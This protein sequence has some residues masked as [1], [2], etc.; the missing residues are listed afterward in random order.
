MMSEYLDILLAFA[1]AVLL[2]FLM[3][4]MYKF[5]R[6]MDDVRENGQFAPLVFT[7]ETPRREFRR[8][9][10]RLS[11]YASIAGIIVALIVY[12]VLRLNGTIGSL[13]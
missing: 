11:K 13:F 7:R 12:S 3:Y 8:Q 2:G 9:Q 10:R 1:I 5:D 6:H 4:R